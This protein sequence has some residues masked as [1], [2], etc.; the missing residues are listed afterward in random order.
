MAA[1][2]PNT[3]NDHLI[4]EG[5]PKLGKEPGAGMLIPREKSGRVGGGHFQVF[6]LR[7][8]GVGGGRCACMYTC[9]CPRKHGGRGHAILRFVTT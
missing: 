7:G 5:P 8:K 4:N 1:I 9:S 6:F 3:K 2:I